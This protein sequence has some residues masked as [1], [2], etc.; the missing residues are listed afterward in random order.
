MDNKIR[1]KEAMS[2]PVLGTA[3]YRTQASRDNIR[4]R[5]EQTREDYELFRPNE[6]VPEDSKRII[7]ACLNMYRRNPLI[8]NIVDLMTDFTVQGIEVVHP[9]KNADVLCK[10]WAKTVRLKHVSERFCSM[11]YKGANVPIYKKWATLTP[12]EKVSLKDGEL[13]VGKDL[14]VKKTSYL[15]KRRIPIQY[16]VLNPLTIELLS[17]DLELFVGE[18][19]YGLRIKD[20]L[21]SIFKSGKATPVE[22]GYIERVPANI[23]DY[24]NKGVKVIPFETEEFKMFFYKKDDTQIWADPMTYAVMEDVIL[25][26]KLKTADLRALDGA[27][28]YIRLWK[29]GKID[30][31]QTPMIPTP[32]AIEKL[33]DILASAGSG[34]P[35]D[36]IWTPDIELQETSVEIS[37]FLGRE[38]YAPALEGIYAGLG[39]PPTLTGSANAGGFTNNFISL[40]TLTERLNYG[41]SILIEFWEEEFRIFQ[42]AMDL[43]EPAQLRFTH[44]TLSDEAAE[45]ALIIQ[46]LDRGI[47]SDDT[48][49]E[50]FGESPLVEKYR[51]KRD[52]QDREKERKP[53]KVGP[54][55]TDNKSEMKKKLL[56][57]NRITPKDVG[58]DIQEKEPVEQVPGNTGGRPAEQGAKQGRAGEGR[59]KNSNDTQKRKTKTVRPRGAAAAN[60]TTTFTWAREAQK[61]ITDIL[62]PIWLEAC[63]KKNMRQLS[64]EESRQIEDLKYAI[65][66]NLEPFSQIDEETIEKLTSSELFIPKYVTDL[67]KRTKEKY[68]RDVSI[69]EY[70]EIQ[71]MVYTFCKG[72]LENGGDSGDV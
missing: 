54:Y 8:R 11:L 12:R 67:I 26:N 37:K 19:R 50:R 14:E 47:I 25:L 49:L 43:R 39:V 10:E 46:L 2:S 34:G 7:S 31:M 59:P 3:V 1:N 66:C 65:L 51:I 44:M 5:D 55:H 4:I 27:I 17:G 64:D 18:L 41:R 30:G 36:I 21:P 6:A 58:I 40:K 38:K 70:R 13:T 20:K 32:E 63:S 52:L 23:Q 42:K 45:L 29:L 62:N 72:D 61:N 16:K 15:K 69:D 35:M 68:S 60:F 33:S 56:E 28:S 9:R 71:A 57:Q 48:V 24:F 53:A 22:T